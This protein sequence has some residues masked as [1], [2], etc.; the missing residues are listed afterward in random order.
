MTTVQR[1]RIG[2]H[3]V[4]YEIDG[5]AHRTEVAEIF[6]DDRSLADWLGVERD[7]GNCGS[8]LDLRQS[9][10]LRERG[11]ALFL[12]REPSYNQNG[13]GRHVLYRCH[14]GSDYCGVISCVLEFDGDHVVWQQITFEDD[15]GPM[16]A[17]HPG[18]NPAQSAFP[19]GAP[20]RFV[21]DRAQYQTELERHYAR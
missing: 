11:L 4:E 12:G 16:L 9:P 20:L 17:P 21:F 10:P 1:L 18:E 19:P 8:D 6:V 13:S 3:V 14:C 2:H 5:V 7:L 15:Q